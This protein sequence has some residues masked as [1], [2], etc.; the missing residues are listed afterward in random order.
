MGT[1]RK[2]NEGQSLQ[3]VRHQNQIEQRHVKHTYDEDFECLEVNEQDL[4]IY[5]DNEVASAKSNS[6]EPDVA[7]RG[8]P[9]SKFKGPGSATRNKRQ[10]TIENSP[11]PSSKLKAAKEQ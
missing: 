11:V 9:E 1:I 5:S 7:S 8:I 2:L 4:L 3:Q 10:A 6:N